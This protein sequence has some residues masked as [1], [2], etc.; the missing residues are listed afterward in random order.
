MCSNS[1]K[2]ASVALTCAAIVYKCTLKCLIYGSNKSVHLK[3]GC[4]CNHSKLESIPK[5]FIVRLHFATK[6]NIRYFYR[7]RFRT[8]FCVCVDLH[9]YYHMIIQKF[10]KCFWLG[11]QCSYGLFTILSHFDAYW[12]TIGFT[13]I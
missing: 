10:A 13:F 12:H 4:L 5:D 3:G 9:A 8:Y 2:W 11:R 1:Y 7:S 6:R